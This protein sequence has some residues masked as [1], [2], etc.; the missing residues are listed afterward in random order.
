[1]RTAPAMPG[2][3]RRDDGILEGNP[4]PLAGAGMGGILP[5]EISLSGAGRDGQFRAGPGGGPE[6]PGH[7]QRG[8]RRG[9]GASMNMGRLARNITAGYAGAAVN[10]VM[11]ILLTPL[12]IRHLGSMEY[13]LWVLAT[14]LGGYFGFLNAGSGAAGVRSVSHHAGA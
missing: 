14:A 8:P 6:V 12:V 2:K 4:A 11:L 13:G 1:R 7:A 3:V 9:E 10:G 5:E